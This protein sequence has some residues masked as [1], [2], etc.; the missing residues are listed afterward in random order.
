MNSNKTIGFTYSG[1]LIQIFIKDIFKKTTII[2]VVVS[3][4]NNPPSPY[5]VIHVI[6]KNTY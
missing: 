6:L 5:L 4:L 1:I 3:K 2:Y